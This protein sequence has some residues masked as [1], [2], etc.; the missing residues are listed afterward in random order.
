MKHIMKS[1]PVLFS[2][3]NREGT[4]YT[5]TSIFPRAITVASNTAEVIL[6]WAPSKSAWQS[7]DKTLQISF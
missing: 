5:V 6:H 3:F 7:V 1:Y 4:V 2:T